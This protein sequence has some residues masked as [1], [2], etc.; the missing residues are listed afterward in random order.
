MKTLSKAFSILAFFGGMAVLRAD[1][2]PPAKPKLTNADVAVKA[3]S[4]RTQIEDDNHQLLQLKQH[5]VK[6]KDVI[7]VNCVNDK[8][9]QAKAE[10][11]IADSAND[12]LQSAIQKNNEDDRATTFGQLE[13]AATAIKQLKEEAAACIGT[14]ELLKQ[15][16]GV[17]VDKPVIPDDPE[18][19]NPF[20]GYFNGGAIEPPAY[21]SP[22]L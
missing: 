9:V 19:T 15:E 6:L 12:S 21:P 4:L 7:K 8:L 22:F 3:A 5:A 18:A 10:M 1:N 17:T 16:A 11:N 20:G 2:P 14:P 13:T